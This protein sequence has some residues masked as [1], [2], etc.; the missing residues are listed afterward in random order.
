M[1]AKSTTVRLFVKMGLKL[2]PERVDRFA[3][4]AFCT[5]RR[6]QV[7]A[8]PESEVLGTGRAGRLNTSDGEVAFWSWG[9]GPAVL[10]VHGWE[11]RAAQWVPMAERLVRSGHRAVMLDLPAHGSSEGSR[12]HVVAFAR[13]GQA[14]TVATRLPRGLRARGGWGTTWVDLPAG[15]SRWRDILTGRVISSPASLDE[16]TASLPVALLIPADDILE[17]P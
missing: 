17:A 11:G 2:A 4:R 12:T 9:Q 3:A 1:S 5:P 10:L 8:V 6:R 15:P 13:A 7:V 14:V 16:L